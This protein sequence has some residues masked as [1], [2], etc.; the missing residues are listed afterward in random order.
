MNDQR[1]R[2]QLT[3]NS[4]SRRTC[5]VPLEL[6]DGGGKGGA[7]GEPANNQSALKVDVVGF[8][9]G[10]DLIM[11]SQR[12]APEIQHSFPLSNLETLRLDLW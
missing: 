3:R 9:F 10:S 11:V 2:Q 1:T 12:V 8:A 5:V 7:A 6:G 4:R